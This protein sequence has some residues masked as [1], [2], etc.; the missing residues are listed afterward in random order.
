MKGLVQGKYANP[1]YAALAAFALA[2][3]GSMAYVIYS[4]WVVSR[5]HVPNVRAAGRVKVDTTLAHLWF[6]ELQSGDRHERPEA[7]WQLL[8]SARFY[9]RAMLEGGQDTQGTIVPLN[10]PE[11]RHNIEDVITVLSEFRVITDAR[12]GAQQSAAPGTAIDQ[13]Y[14]AVFDRLIDLIDGVESR[15]HEVIQDETTF[16]RRVQVIVMGAAALLAMLLGL[17]FARYTRERMQAEKALRLQ[18]R[19]EEE[20]REHLARLAQVARSTTMNELAAGIA[21]EVNQPLA[22]IA[23][24][25]AAC[26]R[27]AESGR[28]GSPEHL[29]ALQLIGSEAERASDVIRRLRR[30]VAKGTVKFELADINDL[31]RSVV[32]LAQFDPQMRT[33]TLQLELSSELPAVEAD[34]VQIEQVLLNLMRNGVEA[35]G[36]TNDGPSEI[37]LRTRLNEDDEVEVA[38]VDRGIG[39]SPS[40]PSD[41][42]M[43]FT[44]T[45]ESGMGIG[46]SISESIITAHGGKIRYRQ[47]T[48]APGTTF[49]FTLPAAAESDES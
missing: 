14:D 8:D 13:E 37:T 23:A 26:R 33:A 10:D 20:A 43:P 40:D 49:Y 22:S 39:L 48:E 35:M 45:K 46:L 30:F 16:V 4:G 5:E 6:E 21:H 24:A 44:T 9:A 17:V 19:A 12:Q 36:G 11:L 32:S 47:N 27:L 34:V 25:A 2:I 29:S 1:F 38:V 28:S 31:V 15:L 41:P 42:F 7:V 3:L 18:V